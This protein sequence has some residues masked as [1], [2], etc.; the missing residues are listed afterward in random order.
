MLHLLSFEHHDKAVA[1]GNKPRLGAIPQC[2]PGV[3]QAAGNRPGRLTP[4]PV[5]LGNKSRTQRHGARVPAHGT[6]RSAYRWQK[7][8][9]G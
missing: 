9:L 6:D 5:L 4:C 2:L 1:M 7:E 8:G 3:Q